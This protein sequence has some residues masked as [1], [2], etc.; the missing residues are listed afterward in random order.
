MEMCFESNISNPDNCQQ[1]NKKL[2]DPKCEMY[3]QSSA[4]SH[5]NLRFGGIK[6]AQ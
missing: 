1:E 3:S 4:S 5:D 2:L 6:G